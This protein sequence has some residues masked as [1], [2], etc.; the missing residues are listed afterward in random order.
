MGDWCSRAYHIIENW[1]SDFYITCFRFFSG[2]L[3]IKDLYHMISVQWP[4]E[5]ELL[6]PIQLFTQKNRMVVIAT[7]LVFLA[8]KSKVV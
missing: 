7:L 4:V 6:V 1:T 5:N 2:M 8:E 3:E